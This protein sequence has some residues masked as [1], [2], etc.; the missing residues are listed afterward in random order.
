MPVYLLRAGETEMIK[1]GWA[2]DLARRVRAIQTAH[3]ETLHI[4]RT[5][6]GPSTAETWL[7]R[8]FIDRR[9]RFEWF[10]F[11]PAML[12]VEI[13]AGLSEK[14]NP[15]CDELLSAFG[16]R[17]AVARITGAKLNAITQWRIAGVPHRHW[18]PLLD[19]AKEQGLAS[20]NPA[21]LERTRPAKI[22]VAA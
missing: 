12:V 13:P 21:L 7:H 10:R 4:I 8:R 22:R 5:I 20:V 1:I 3:Y 15:A 17:A 19:A 11:D 6:E 2:D 16:G 9:V 14:A 18:F